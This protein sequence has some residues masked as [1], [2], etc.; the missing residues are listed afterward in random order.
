MGGEAGGVRDHSQEGAQSWYCHH[1]K[2]FTDCVEIQIYSGIFFLV[3]VNQFQKLEL[4]SPQFN[5]KITTIIYQLLSNCNEDVEELLW[6]CSLKSLE[7]VF[8]GE[9]SEF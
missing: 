2:P 8:D 7:L 6:N 5:Y 9:F 1:Y 3:S 4:P